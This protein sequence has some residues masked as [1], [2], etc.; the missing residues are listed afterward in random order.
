MQHA[1][2]FIATLIL[3][4]GTS[5]G[6]VY[7]AGVPELQQG[8]TG[9]CF[10]LYGALQDRDGNLF[11]S[12]YSISTALAMTYAGA[13]GETEKEMAAVLHLPLEQERLHKDFADLQ[14][15][16]N[17]LQDKGKVQLN[18][19]NA[20]WAQEGQPFLD[21]FVKLTKKYYGAGVNFVD[22]A[23][24]TEAARKV[25]NDW[26]EEQTRNKIQELIKQG[27]LDPSTILVLCNAI[28]FKGDWLSK[29]E[30]AATR[31]VDFFISPDST[32]QVPMMNQSLD[33]K[34]RKFDG[35]S[36]V[37]LPYI[38]QKLSMVAVLPEAKDGL[39]ALEQRLSGDQVIQWLAELKESRPLKVEISLPRFKTTCEFE[40]SEILS[41]MGMPHAFSDADFSGMTGE[42]NLYIS[43]VVH[44]AYVD[45]NEE[46]TEAAAATAVIMDKA[47]SVRP[48]VFRADHPF[49]FLIRENKTGSILFM[50][51][52]TDPTK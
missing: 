23:G 35:F 10:D 8:N 31:D 17:D 11:F 21:S 34:Y 38:G 40:L 26:V 1:S 14:K 13:R 46:G 3:F 41:K 18:V 6:L 49:L 28:Y 12:P 52:I 2:L 15:H 24:A 16:L 44:K 29:F 48:L 51:R 32:V 20:L 5:S 50:G 47:L 39:S 19:A 22:Y 25:I 43:K 36:A 37:E 45:V 27:M 42:K 4:A 30:E 9:F 33:V 7:A